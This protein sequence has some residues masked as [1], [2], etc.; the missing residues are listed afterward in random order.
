MTKNQIRYFYLT[1]S[2]VS[3]TV[4]ELVL[5]YPRGFLSLGLFL[6]HQVFVEP[7]IL[8]VKIH[9]CNFAIA[10]PVRPLVFLPHDQL[11]V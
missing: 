11:I 1:Y 10:L 3:R 5:Y 9:N 2:L 8:V 7:H 4:H 6:P